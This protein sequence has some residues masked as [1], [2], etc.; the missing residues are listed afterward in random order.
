MTDNNWKMPDQGEILNQRSTAGIRITESKPETTALLTYEA[1]REPNGEM[2]SW[3]LRDANEEAVKEIGQP[4]ESLINKRVS[5]LI[6]A[7]IPLISNVQLLQEVLETG[8]GRRYEIYFPWNGK[9]FQISIFPLKNHNGT[10]SQILGI[11]DDISEQKR[12]EKELRE[13]EERFRGVFE[14]VAIGIEQMDLD[15]RIMNINPMMTQILGYSREELAGKTFEEITHPEDLEQE[16]EPLCQLYTGTVSSYTLEKRYLRKDGSPVWIRVTS[17]LTH[18]VS[19]EPYSRISVIEDITERKQAERTLRVKQEELTAANEELQAQQEELTG[20]NEELQAQTEE[21]YNTYQ[22][23][24]CQAN[25]IRQYAETADRAR[26][27]AEQRA[28]ELDATISSIAAGAVIYDNSGKIIRMNEFA[29]S[30]LGYSSEDYNVPYQDRRVSLNLCKSDGTPYQLEETPLYRALH[31]EIIRD[32]E[33]IIARLQ[34]EPM[35]LSG[36]LA[37]IQDSNANTLGVVFIFIDITGRKQESTQKI[38]NILESITDCFYALDHQGRFTYLNKGTEIF[39]GKIRAD[40]LG[41]VIWEEYPQAVNELLYTHFH[42]AMVESIPMT[43]ETG[44]VVTDRWYEYR[45]YPSKDGL[46]VY[47]RDITEKKQSEK[48]IQQIAAIVEN[49]EDAIISMSPSGRIRSWNKGAMKLYGYTA[50]EILEQ[51]ALILI[52]PESQE[53]MRFVL[54]NINMEEVFED[55]DAIRLRKDGSRIHVSIKTSTIRDTEGNIVELSSIQ[56]DITERVMYEE[57]LAKERELLMVTLNSLA[58]GV[59]AAD[60][61]ERI[62]LINEAAA[63]Q[64]GYSQ[65]EAIGELLDKVLYLIDD[66]TSEPILASLSQQGSRYPVLVTR[67]LREV[68]VAVDSSPIKVSDGRIIGTVTVLEDISEKQKIERELLKTAKLESLGILAGGIAH[69][70]NNILAAILSNVQLAMLKLKKNE[71]ITPY[72]SNTVETT[73]KASDLTKQLLTFSKG[74]VPVKK[75]A[76]LIN[77]IKDTVEFVLRGANTKAEF[78]I[79][80][81]LW[82][83][84]IDEGQISQVIHNL[85]INAKQAMPKGGI[86]NINAENTIIGTE[87]SLDPGKYVKITVKDQGLGI[88]EE[89]LSKIFDPF[90]TTKKDGNGLGLA[91]SY[92]IIKQHKGYIEVES[93]EGTGTTFFIYLPAS[94]AAVLQKESQDEAAV[95]GAGFK[96][97]L[98]DDEETILNAVGEMLECYGYQVFLTTDGAQAIESYKQ[99]KVTGEPFMVIIMDLTVPGGMG[100]QE[101]IAHLRDFDPKVKA[102]V[103]SGYANDPIM[104]DYERYGFVGVVSKPYKIDELNEVLQKV[105]RL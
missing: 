90:F 61:E 64:T 48:T 10:I 70:F 19:G 103:S 88:S 102:I 40:L 30:L 45:I 7:K 13:S 17:S 29:R 101:A 72:L 94:N 92:S 95:T 52:P 97:L 1:V 79:P 38:T 41:K 32:E 47:F 6:E 59:V 56:R 82:A 73:R 66:K 87:T 36:T 98:M 33:M 63:N 85:V 104:S 60:Q 69:D 26:Y 96:I 99:A 83:A 77:L 8:K 46:S 2:I 39:Y 42:K 11:I 27:E 65:D 53:Q 89:N 84:N 37:P 18:N 23:L 25:E 78:S 74:G 100:G 15:D 62:I 75:D 50:G 105:L 16:W 86:I 57:A 4:Q 58:E 35:W 71:D 3:I 5:D 93:Q 81:N 76:S 14:Q 43:F 91:T 80:G 20:L 49:S 28:A 55:N 34:G 22:E 24:Q 9:F 31:G 21:L 51:S 44:S 54:E 68:P 67:D 12:V